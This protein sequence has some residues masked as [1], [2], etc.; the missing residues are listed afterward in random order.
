MGVPEDLD[1]QLLVR[2]SPLRREST[3]YKPH[4]RPCPAS[5]SP[6]IIAFRSSYNPI[7]RAFFLLFVL[8][9]WSHSALSEIVTPCQLAREL[10]RAGVPKNEWNRWVCIAKYES[11]FNT[12]ARSPYDWGLFQIYCMTSRHQSGAL[13]TSRR[14][15][16]GK[17]GRSSTGAGDTHLTFQTSRG[18]V[19][20][21]QFD[22]HHARLVFIARL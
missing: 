18:P 1:P 2:E 22:H 16:N 9:L 13:G 21:E 7:M 4:L 5:L 6:T 8:A 17:P 15:R 3:C 11:G 20:C 12:L 10:K 14:C 19:F